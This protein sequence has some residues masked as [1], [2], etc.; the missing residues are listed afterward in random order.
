MDF[1][2]ILEYQKKDGEL[3]R[4]EREL[5]SHPSKKVSSEMIAVVKSAQEKSAKLEN[6]AGVLAKDFEA[7][8]KAYDENVKQIEKFVSKDLETVSEKDLESITVA[9]NAI[10][11]N[12][13]VLEK[14]LF[15]EAENL[16]IAL[17]EFEAAKKQYGTARAKYNE[18]KQIYDSFSKTKEPDILRVKA[19]LKKLEP[20]IEPKLLA[21]YTQLRSDRLFPVFVRLI[22]KSCGGCRM[23]LSAA[24]VEKV[25]TNGYMECDNCHRVII[26]E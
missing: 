19:E 23:E 16:N 8:K 7:L 4:I 15:A 17:N 18:H 14:K 26:S 20:G 3:I 22:E 10:I 13:N 6:R 5:M 21:K 11:N 9:T 24:E 2:N 12:L 25:K 1:K